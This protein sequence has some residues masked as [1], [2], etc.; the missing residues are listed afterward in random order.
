MN[1]VRAERIHIAIYGRT[2][3]GKSSL[4]N[5][6]TGQDAAIVSDI[7]GTT[8]DP[9]NK[10]MEVPG[11]GAVTFIDT[12]GFDDKGA[13]GGE[14]LERTRQTADRTDVAIIVLVPGGDIPEEAEWISMFRERRTPVI[15]VIN[16]T[17]TLTDTD[18]FAAGV[19]ARTGLRPIPVSAKTG[20]GIG[21]LI[22]AISQVARESDAPASILGDMVAAGDVVM[23]VMPQDS[24][25][26]N[27]R[28]ILP[29][30]QVMR[31]LLD[32][33]CITVGCVPEDMEA[34]LGA[35]SAPPELVVTDS[36]AFATVSSLTPPE[37]RL[38]SFSVLMA[39]HK[40]DIKK[41]MEGAAAIDRL[42]AD[43]RVLIAEAC[44]HAPATEDIGRVK[45]PAMLRKRVGQGLKVD[46][47]GGADFPED[48]TVYDLVI[49][50]GACMFNR[51][52]VISRIEKAAAQGVPITNYGIAIAYLTSILDKVA[53][54]GQL[55]MVN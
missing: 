40:G 31:E 3:S 46:V 20:A 19:E 30:V 47:V 50:C 22:E 10:S 35:L 9:V 32:R 8:T 38:T 41:F 43:S 1:K 21:T 28:L 51:R 25:A 44:T 12:A 45:I 54:P 53:Y 24:Q 14:R 6:I 48:L 26:P 18:T 13:L 29:Q 42:T 52:H 17:D 37:S 2:N 23:L 11:L 15:A 34:A 4:I 33:K 55:K 16:K 36:Q 27:G 7:A 5:A 39:H 49:H